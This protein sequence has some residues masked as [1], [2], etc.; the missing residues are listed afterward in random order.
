MVNSD[1]DQSESLANKAI[2]RARQFNPEF[3][4]NINAGAIIIFQIL[5]SFF[6]G[7]FRRFTTI[8]GDLGIKRCTVQVQS[9]PRVGSSSMT[10]D[11]PPQARQLVLTG[12]ST[13]WQSWQREPNKRGELEGQVNRPSAIAN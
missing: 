11:A 5:V 2:I 4:I 3:I 6:M 8:V 13:H 10:T 1:D 12:N 9:V 7:R